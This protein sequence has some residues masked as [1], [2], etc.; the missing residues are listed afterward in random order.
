MRPP[1]R[2]RGS[3]RCAVLINDKPVDALPR[4]ERSFMLSRVQQ[5]V[6]ATVLSPADATETYVA[7]T[8]KWFV[9]LGAIALVLMAGIA[10]VGL[11]GDPMDGA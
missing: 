7:Q 4:Q 5:D 9:I 1:K 11:V 3:I 10:V 2:R 8:K 6:E